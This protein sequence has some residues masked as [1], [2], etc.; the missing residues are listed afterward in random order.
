MYLVDSP[1]A[2]DL[3]SHSY[4]RGIQAQ[5]KQSECQSTTHI[6]WSTAVEGDPKASFSTATTPRR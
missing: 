1:F 4:I 3:Y 6:S 2:K 5:N